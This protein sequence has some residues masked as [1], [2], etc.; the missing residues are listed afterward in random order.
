MLVAADLDVVARQIG[1]AP[2]PFVDVP[3]RCGAG[4]PV[5]IEQPAHDVDGSPFPTTFWLTCPGLV[6]AIGKL[7]AAGGVATL[8]ARVASEEA[9]RAAYAQGRSDQVA[10]RPVLG[11]LGVGGTRRDGAIKCLHAHAAFALARPGYAVGDLIVAA[12]GGVPSPC[13]MEEA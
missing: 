3:A 4:R 7:E 13:C 5:V 8:E 6:A 10:L 1:R 11:E 2:R 12:A 9:L